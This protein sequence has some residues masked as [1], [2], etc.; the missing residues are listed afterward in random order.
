MHFSHSFLLFGL[1]DHFGS[2]F[3]ATTIFGG[4]Q[5]TFFPTDTPQSCL[6]AFNTS[7]SCD[8]TAQLLV[9]QTD[10]VG[11]NATNLTALCTSGCRSSLVAL[12]NT[13]NTSCS[14]WAGGSLGSDKLDATTMMEFILYKYDMTCLADG[15][16]FCHIQRQNWDIPA[17][18]SANKATWP[19]N[20]NKTYYNWYCE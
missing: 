5:A 9:K 8:N 6:A 12:Q 11:W 4:K 16:T 17:M 20:T 18:I 10:W 3:G 19:K 14:S 13:V 15:A 1:L 2:V 7:L